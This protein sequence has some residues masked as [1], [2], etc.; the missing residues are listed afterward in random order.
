MSELSSLLSSAIELDQLMPLVID[1]AK[2]DMDAEACSILFYNR[3]TNKLEFEVAIC[4]E[5]DTCSVLKKMISLDIGQGIAGGL[6]NR[7]KRS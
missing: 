1:R 2:Q 3:E 5:D 6:P 4:A 7:K